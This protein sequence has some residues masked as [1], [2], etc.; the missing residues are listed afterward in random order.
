MD[1]IGHCRQD[2]L[3]GPHIG[4]RGTAQGAGD[5]SLDGAPR[6]PR[7][8]PSA[9]GEPQPHTPAVLGIPLAIEETSA[10]QSLEDA[11]DGARVEEDDARQFPRGDARKPPH[12]P[13]YEPLGPR[14]PESGFHSLR[15]TLETVF[16]GPQQPEEIQGRIQR[17]FVARWHIPDH[18]LPATPPLDVPARSLSE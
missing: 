16:D 1:R 17:K 14:D 8:R 3:G 15:R 7:E 10:H 6:Y 12:D 13:E 9:W 2:V 18:T 5:R 4:R 11:R